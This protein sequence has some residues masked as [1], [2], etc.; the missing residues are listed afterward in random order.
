MSL[1]FF[2]TW[3]M[4]KLLKEALRLRFEYYNIYESKE[5]KW[6]KKYKNHKLYDVVVESFKYDFKQIAQK[7]PELLKKSL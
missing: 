2:Y 6:H 3:N 1:P 4:D 5:E 7:M